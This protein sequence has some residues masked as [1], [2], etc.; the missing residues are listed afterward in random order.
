MTML[1]RL[2]AL[3]LVAV[4]AAAVG[5]LLQFLWGLSAGIRARSSKIT[6][7]LV[8]VALLVVGVGACGG[9]LSRNI[10]MRQYDA[11]RLATFARRIADTDRVVATCR[12]DRS[13]RLTFA[14]DAA[15][16]V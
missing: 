6:K 8:F 4:A 3:P 2:T 14:G 1:T 12:E 13:T 15:K 10:I 7:R 5:W 16:R 9:Y 11:V